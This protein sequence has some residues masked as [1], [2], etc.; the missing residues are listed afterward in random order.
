MLTPEQQMLSLERVGASAH[1]FG[2]RA[3]LS[4]EEIDRGIAKHFTTA[5]AVFPDTP[6][7]VL[8]RLYRTCG[9]VCRIKDRERW[10]SARD[11]TTGRIEG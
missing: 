3:T 5:Q 10:E 1:R 2:S 9:V 11:G 4:T 8:A 7:A 6:W